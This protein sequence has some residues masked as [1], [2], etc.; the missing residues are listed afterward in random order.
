MENVCLFNIG[1]NEMFD[2]SFSEVLI[3]ELKRE[4]IYRNKILPDIKSGDVFP[5]IRKESMGFYHRGGELFTFDKVFRTHVKFAS[6]LKQMQDTENPYISESKLAKLNG[7]DKFIEGYERIK[8][9]CSV[10]SSQEAIGV[11]SVYSKY[12][13]LL[14]NM[15]KVVL[16]IEVAFN[17]E[18]DFQYESSK[19]NRERIDILFFNTKNCCLTFCE[20]KHFSNKEIMAKEGKPPK[21]VKQIRRYEKTIGENQKKKEILSAYKEYVNIV[22]KAFSLKLPS[23]KNINPKMLLLIFGFDSD[24]RA[25]RFK[26][27]FKNNVPKDIKIYAKGDIKSLEIESIKYLNTCEL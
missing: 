14:K 22:N 17:S 4:D 2:R 15:G 6:V 26:K 10:F 9:N 11:S 3:D 8:E 1:G 27:Y 23:P 18:K 16:D 12:S 7:I 21:V 20:A 25:G 19:N 13:Y 24:Q 5:A